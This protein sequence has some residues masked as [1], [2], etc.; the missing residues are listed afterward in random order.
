MRIIENIHV[1]AKRRRQAVLPRRACA[2]ELRSGGD[3]LLTGGMVG[4]KEAR[5]NPIDTRQYSDVPSREKKTR[6]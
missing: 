2:R 4:K 3:G 5:T 6:A 1:G